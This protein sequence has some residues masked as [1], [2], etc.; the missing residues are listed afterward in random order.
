MSVLR[1]IVAQQSIAVGTVRENT[2]LIIRTIQHV[3][4]VLKADIVV[5]PELAL[6]GY[7][8]EDLLFRV[9]FHQQVKSAL[10]EVCQH[11]TGIDVV[12]GYP[13]FQAGQTYNAA[14]VIRDKNI[15]LNYHKQF[16]P[17][18]GVFDEKRYYATG[19]KPGIFTNK[20][21]KIGLIICQDIWHPEPIEQAKQAGA[22]V[23]LCPNASPFETTKAEIR[24]EVIRERISEQGLPVIYSHFICGQDDVIFDG[25]SFAMDKDFS[26]AAYAPFFEE[27]LLPVEIDTNTLKLIPTKITPKTEEVERTYQALVFAVREYVN[28]N[29]IPGAL[30]GVSGGID[31]ALVLAL[32]VDALGKKRVQAV[33]LPSAYTS[34]L[35]MRLADELLKNIGVHSTCISIENAYND[36]TKDLTPLFKDGL[37]DLTQQNLQARCRG[38]IMMALSNQTSHIVLTTSNKSETAVGYSTLYGD[39]AGGFSPLKDVYKTF[40]YRLAKYRNTITPIIPEEIIT[41]PPTAE[42]APNQRDQDTLPPYE[43]LDQILEEYVEKDRSISDIVDLGFNEAL[44][45]NVIKMI[46][47]NE[48]KRRQAPIGPRITPRAFGRE[49][50]YPITSG[51]EPS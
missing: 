21:V 30:V 22:Q 31:S 17:N 36:F 23:I 5:F 37:A 42:L 49:R 11:V 3:R 47:R 24:E 32:A 51:F 4:D 35:S 33:L 28:K 38:I 12:L 48:Y 7:P 40:V 6:S 26:I 25:G 1:I 13:D 27:T 39:M 34:E 29:N 18:F 44:V 46:D 15:I 2:Q 8:P 45:R 50:R 16:L 43:I 9:D 10:D 19:N 20:G 14:C 41:R